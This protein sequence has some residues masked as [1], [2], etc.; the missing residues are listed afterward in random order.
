MAEKTDIKSETT[1][2]LY[3]TFYSTV[4]ARDRFVSLSNKASAVIQEIDIELTRRSEEIA[5][6]GKQI[7]V[8][9]K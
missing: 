7:P 2:K 8:V 9:E 3:N 4:K 1:E 5:L 6:K